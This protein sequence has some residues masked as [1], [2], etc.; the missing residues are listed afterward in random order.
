MRI[1]NLCNRLLL[2]MLKILLSHI[3]LLC[4][5]ELSSK[6]L[7]R[8]TELVNYVNGDGMTPLHLLASK[9]SAF[10]SGCHLKWFENIIYNCKYTIK[11]SRF[12]VSP[13]NKDLQELKIPLNFYFYLFP[14]NCCYI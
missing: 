13:V 7:H 10:K 4:L 3:W 5:A 8:Y 14:I 11:F 6:I 9:P 12:I 1:G 2:D